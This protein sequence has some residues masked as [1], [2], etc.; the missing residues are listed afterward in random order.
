MNYFRILNDIENSGMKFDE[1]FFG[2]IINL[3]TVG[4]V[5]NDINNYKVPLKYLYIPREAVHEDSHSFGYSKVMWLD[6][7]EEYLNRFWNKKNI[8]VI[9]SLLND[10]K[11]EILFAH[12]SLL[13][14]KVKKW[15]N[16]K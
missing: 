15:L 4:E 8:Y 2:Q 16:C 6:A 1:T 9:W 5:A 3:A 11:Y 10:N 13:N 12:K 14:D 7:L